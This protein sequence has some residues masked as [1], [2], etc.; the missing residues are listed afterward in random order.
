M[1][2]KEILSTPLIA[3]EEKGILNE[4]WVPKLQQL[5]FFKIFVP[6]EL[7]G[8]ALSL[9]EATPY[10]LATARFHGSL[11][12]MHNL[13]AGANSFC[14]YF[15]EEVAHQIFNN[16]TVMCSGSGT[17]NGQIS[18]NTHQMLVSG[19]WSKCT[20]AHWATHFTAVAKHMDNKTTTFI[21]P[22]NQVKIKKDW[23]GF[24][25]KGTSTDQIEMHNV[26]LPIQYQ[27]EIGQQ[28]S[29]LHY[30]IAQINFVAFA[31]IC[32]S[33]TFEG[34]VLRLLDLIEAQVDLNK[35]ELN[36][37]INEVKTLLGSLHQYRSNQIEVV[38]KQ[39]NTS[40]FALPDEELPL[41]F[42]NIHAEISIQLEKLI[43]KLG[44]LS[45]DERNKIHWA[46]RDVKVAI[47]HY[48]V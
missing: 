7:G 32:M 36:Y 38:S 34:L 30:P 44:M 47:Q 6:K 33:I 2:L 41:S 28:K 21:C 40:D 16:D 31:K 39:S 46:Y 20:G 25:L 1:N 27:F 13:V 4:D 37:T 12:W 35:K 29:F 45:I 42:S 11:G 5:K 14:T 9:S 26:E 8:L 18:F 10:L 19:K 22:A 23:F 17:A 43:L 3:N 15:E 48:Y 24:G